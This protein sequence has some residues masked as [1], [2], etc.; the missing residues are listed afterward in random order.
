T[1]VPLYNTGAWSKYDQSS[2]SD[3]NYH[4]LLAEFLEHLCEKT[5]KGEPLT[6]A[7]PPGAQAPSAGQT[8]PGAQA[9][10]PAQ[11]SPIPGDSIYCTTAESFRADEKTPPVIALLT[12]NLRTGERAGV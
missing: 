4:E 10:P 2:E 3:L 9:P 11:A 12:K 5:G 6:A 7:I 8:P 1:E